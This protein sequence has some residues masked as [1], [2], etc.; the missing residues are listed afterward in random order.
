MYLLAGNQTWDFSARVHRWQ[1]RREF[2]ADVSK[3]TA[4]KP[5]ASHSRDFCNFTSSAN[6]CGSLTQNSTR[7]QTDRACGKRNRR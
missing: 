6:F 4:F 2:T 7:S 5:T 3:V 1:L